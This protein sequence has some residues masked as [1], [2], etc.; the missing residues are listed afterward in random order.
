MQHVEGWVEEVETVQVWGLEQML[1]NEGS[2]GK[3]TIFHIRLIGGE[4]SILKMPGSLRKV[5]LS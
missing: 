3:G 1:S 2:C 4:A 5:F